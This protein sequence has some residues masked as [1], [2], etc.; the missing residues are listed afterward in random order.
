MAGLT[1]ETDLE[2]QMTMAQLSGDTAGQRRLAPLLA[3][4]EGRYD[5][6]VPA[7]LNSVYPDIRVTRFQDW[8]LRNWASIP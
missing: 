2:Y 8:F 6:V 3:T 5:F 7:Y 4:A 1:S